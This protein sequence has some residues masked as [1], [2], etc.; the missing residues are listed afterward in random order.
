MLNLIVQILLISLQIQTATAST[1][2]CQKPFDLDLGKKVY[3]RFC[4]IPAAQ[5]VLMGRKNGVANET[6]IVA[7]NFKSFQV[8]QTE[9]TQLQYFTVTGEN[10]WINS[11]DTASTHLKKTGDNYPAM[12]VSFS[13]TKKFFIE[14]LNKIDPTA[15]YR[16]LTEAEW[17]Y[18]ARGKPVT[19]P[20]DLKDFYWESGQGPDYAVYTSQSDHSENP[21]SEVYSCPNQVL[22]KK[23]PGYCANDFGLLHMLGNVWELTADTSDDFEFH[24][25]TNVF[26]D[27]NAIVGGENDPLWVMA[28]GGGSHNALQHLPVSNRA[29]ASPN[30]G[31]LNI[32]L[33][34]AR[35]PKADRP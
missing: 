27:G 26:V 10:P 6:P 24:P 12:Y 30:E 31:K 16:L 9:V 33:R 8:A 5:G 17:E 22:Q 4:E 13:D 7:K 15:T 14:K 3:M 21:A 20:E 34:I 29:G 35:F 25:L 1:A 19:K 18:A 11:K 2:K 23:D 28:R 32:G